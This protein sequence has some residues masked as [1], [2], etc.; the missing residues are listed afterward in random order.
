MSVGRSAGGIQHRA[1]HR[2]SELEFQSARV[3]AGELW[4]HHG[5]WITLLEFQPAGVPAGEPEFHQVGGELDLEKNRLVCLPESFGA[6]TVGGNLCLQSNQLLGLPGSFGAIT[7]G[8]DLFLNCPWSVHSEMGPALAEA[9]RLCYPNVKGRVIRGIKQE[10]ALHTFHNSPRGSNQPGTH[11]Q[12]FQTYS[13]APAL[14]IR[15]GGP[16][17]ADALA[18]IAVEAW[19]PIR[20]GQEARMGPEEFASKHAD[21]EAN[22]AAKVHEACQDGFAGNLL[23]GTI[24]GLAVGFVSWGLHQWDHMDPAPI[25]EIWNNAVHC[26]YQNRGI[27]TQ[28]YMAALAR[29]HADGLES[30]VVGCGQHNEP[31]CRAYAK[32]GFRRTA[33]TDSHLCCELP[34]SPILQAT[35]VR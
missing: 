35:C 6:M 33:P 29:M 26:G 31:A 19:R 18:Q 25:G 15:T 14:S 20:A 1:H 21:W 34:V 11:M 10:L 13:E 16:A 23:V 5:G 22:K 30:A 9:S 8:G 28:L 12:G 24:D 17:D 4:C 32:V 27:G 7:V 2:E 3:P